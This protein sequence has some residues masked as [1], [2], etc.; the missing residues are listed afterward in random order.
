MDASSLEVFKNRLVSHSAGTT[1]EVPSSSDSVFRLGLLTLF[2]PGLEEELVP[3]S[4]G[5]L[6]L[7][8]KC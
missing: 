3:F 6:L 8:A 2:N 7:H 1:P 5:D 4:E